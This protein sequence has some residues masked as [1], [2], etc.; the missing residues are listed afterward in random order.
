MIA[1]IQVQVWLYWLRPR[2]HLSGIR[3]PAAV[4]GSCLGNSK[5]RA[6]IYNASLLFFL[7]SDH[8]W[9]RGFPES[10]I[11][12]TCKHWLTL[13]F[14]QLNFL[15]PKHPLLRSFTDQKTLRVK[16]HLLFFVS[17]LLVAS[18]DDR[19]FF[20]WKRKWTQSL[21]SCP[22][23]SGLHVLSVTPTPLIITA[24]PLWTFSSTKT[25]L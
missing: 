10:I 24:V 4:T 23:C 21:L 22:C 20:K 15:H 25:P 1:A 18:L 11:N 13:P 6:S 12:Y 16:N 14:N 17:W 3:S 7:T 19:S 5:I 2:V 8:F 9:H